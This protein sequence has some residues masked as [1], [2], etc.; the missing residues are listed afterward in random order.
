M[1]IAIGQKLE[2]DFR[3]PLGLLSDCH[4]RIER[5]LDGLIVISEQAR[6]ESTSL[7]SKQSS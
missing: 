3:D 4:R 1:P 6:G 5:F 7:F 2:S